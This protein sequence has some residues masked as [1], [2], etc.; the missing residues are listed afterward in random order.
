MHKISRQASRDATRDEA[1]TERTAQDCVSEA[2]VGEV[3]LRQQPRVVQR[4]LADLPVARVDV[5]ARS[6]QNL[7]RLKS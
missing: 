1:A 5:G 7:D 2:L 4:R 6:H 3:G